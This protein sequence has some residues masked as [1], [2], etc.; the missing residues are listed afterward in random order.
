MTR[1]SNLIISTTAF[2]VT[3][4]SSTSARLI[5]SHHRLASLRNFS[6]PSN[7]NVAVTWFIPTSK[8]TTMATTM[9]A[10]AMAMAT[11]AMT[12]TT[13]TTT[14][15]VRLLRNLI[16]L[17]LHSATNSSTYWTTKYGPGT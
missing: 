12:T 9:T 8:A 16:F 11:T 4:T 13:T 2:A 5:L 1:P 7:L 15:A 17:S 14:A 10:I 3:P 6:K